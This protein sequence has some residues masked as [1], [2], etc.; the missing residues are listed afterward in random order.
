MRRIKEE[1]LSLLSS[2]MLE[3]FFEKEEMQQMFK[4]IE[5]SKAKHIATEIVYYELLYMYKY[6]DIFI[7]D[8]NITGAIVGIEAKKIFTFKRI[9]LSFKASKVFKNFSKKEMKCLTDN[10][11]IIKEVHSTKWFKK[12]DKNPYYF[13]QFGIDKRKRG[14][15]IAR[16]MLEFLFDY[17][18]SN[19]KNIVLETLTE[20]NVPI[21]EHFGFELKE[22]N[23]TEKE[24]MKEYRMLK[25]LF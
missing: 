18:K 13:A 5:P 9:L 19:F 11:V 4:N 14:E 16:E 8:D 17:T 22:Q 10:I 25:R 23:S 12:Y 7:Y 24:Q 6:G 21:Y 3:Q 2:F 1:E 20:S 15:G